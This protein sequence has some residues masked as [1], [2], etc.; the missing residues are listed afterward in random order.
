ME[1]TE[2]TRRLFTES[3]A[4]MRS[5]MRTMHGHYLTDAAAFAAFNPALGGTFGADWLTAID[6]ADLAPNVDAR[7]GELREDT[8]AVGSGME[9]A[10][11]VAQQVFYYVEQA[12]PKNKGR[13]SQ[14]GKDRYAKAA[15]DSEEMRLLL[16]MAAQAAER[17]K[18]ELAAH[19]FGPQQLADL[20]ALATRL[21]A[22]DT[23]QEMQKG[24]NQEGTDDY[25]RLQNAAF[26]FGQQLNKA[27][28]LAFA[29]DATKR[30]LY[31]L[32]DADPDAAARP[33][34]SPQPP[35]A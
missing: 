15:T 7:R 16:D 2:S 24:T 14:Y 5:R 6:T 12:F 31:R 19:G 8:A 30:Q 17:D 20:K 32:S 21:D 23:A 28:K 29:A 4:A 34:K 18:T 1:P 9:Q 33:G 10:K 26:G 22:V 27:A 11:R 35:T 3:D 25:V 13:L